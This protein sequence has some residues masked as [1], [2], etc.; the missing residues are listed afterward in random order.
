ML[1]LAQ[2]KQFKLVLHKLNR[3]NQGL[4]MDEVRSVIIGVVRSLQGLL[5]AHVVG[6]V[7]EVGRL[8]VP[9]AC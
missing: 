9:F 4:T 6:I 5:I 1:L 2:L 3:I 8:G 7:G